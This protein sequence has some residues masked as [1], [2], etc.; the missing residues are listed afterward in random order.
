MRR[1]LSSSR[2]SACARSGSA[3]KALPNPPCGDADS[4][5][6]CAHDPDRRCVGELIYE[7]A[8]SEGR[9]GLERLERTV[10]PSRDAKLEGTA[11]ILNYYFQKD[12]AAPRTSSRSARTS[13]PASP[14]RGRRWK[15]SSTLGPDAVER[16]SARARLHHLAHPAAGP[17]TGRIIIEVNVDAFGETDPTLCERMMRDYVRLVRRHG[18]GIPVCV[19]SGSPEILKA[20]L[21]AWYEDAPS[22]IAPPLLNSVKPYTM[23]EFLPLRDRRPFQFVGL[24]VDQKSSSRTPAAPTTGSTSST[25]WP[26]R[27]FRAAVGKYG[28]KPGDIFFDSTVFPLAIDMPMTPGHPGLH[29]SDLRDDP[30]DQER[31]GR[32]GRPLFARHHQRRPRP[33]RTPDGRLPRLPRPGRGI[34]P[35]RR[36]RQRPPRLRQEAAGPRAR[37]IRRRL[38]QPGRL[39]RAAEG[40][41]RR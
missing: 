34:R 17:P 28:F 26:G 3:P 19:D 6:M 4:R 5:G 31:S 29:L 11:S 36:D 21:E 37:G 30:P 10:N 2:T 35:R 16:P 39:S 22:A 9:S 40:R 8:V 1:L 12:H 41:R 23:D 18:R 33:P 14:G 32:C 24:L 25:A 7:A 15:R 13:M 38:R 20:G 27:I